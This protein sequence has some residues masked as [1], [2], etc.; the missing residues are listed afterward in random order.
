MAA[1][2][3]LP[4]AALPC[5][6]PW[7]PGDSSLLQ[8]QTAG[9][10]MIWIQ[11]YTPLG[12]MTLS[13]LLAVVPFALLCWQ[14]VIKRRSGHVAIATALAAAFVLAAAWQMPLS[15]VAS[16]TLYGAA[17]GLFPMV[18]I[19]FPAMWLYNMTVDSGQFAIVRASIGDLTPD[20]RIQAIFI[21][22]AF[23]A[24]LESTSGSGSP[25]AIG[26]AMLIG[27]GFPPI[28]A[29]GI[30]LLANTVP[31]AFANM[32][33]PLLVAGQVSELNSFYI[34]QAVG[35]QLPLVALFV[36]A[37]ICL[38]VCGLRRTRE[39]WPVLLVAGLGSSIP[40]CL[41]AN[42]HG[43]VLAGMGGAV[44]S[45]LGITVLLRVWRP[46][47]TLSFTENGGILERDT[48]SLPTGSAYSAKETF[49]A[50]LPWVMLTLMVFVSNIGPVRS[51]L[52]GIFSPVIQ[53]PLIDQLVIKTAPL[54]AQDTPSAALLKLNLLTAPGSW[55]AATALLS[56][57]IIPGYSYKRTFLVLWQT[58]YQMRFAILSIM[59][60]LAMAQ[61]MNYS[62]MSYTLGLAFTQ[63]GFLFPLLSP[64]LGWIG[65]F[66]TG[67]DTSSNALFCGMQRTTAEA[68]GMNPYLATAG[69]TTGGITAKMVSPQSIA[70]AVGATGLVG[71]EGDL[72]RYTA[73]HS[74]I[75]LGIICLLTWLQSG[76]LAFMIPV[77]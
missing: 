49:R 28:Q 55:I 61:L 39:I 45:L 32:G 48:A 10:K 1:R 47:R 30:C 46:A 19:V 37:W 62:G 4:F 22:F 13:A 41:L 56:P 71:R 7:M 40:T 74:F 60:I 8:P 70:V 58:V 24:L 53:W 65:V 42:F 9:E 34:G 25:V 69:N 20:I 43:V 36:P 26:A 27:L 15:K 29:A 72:L 35:R 31:V 51:A 77:F 14:L 38:L 21:A 50:W 52:D 57:F 64:I 63:I 23:G 6:K 73:R 17:Y 66:F 33:L 75:M 54:V 18:W 3:R 16:A 44:G 59:M 5:P 68:V 76:P 2:G 67:S 12:N 11:E